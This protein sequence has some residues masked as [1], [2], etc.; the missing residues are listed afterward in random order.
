MNTDP[1]EIDWNS[2]EHLLAIVAGVAPAT[3][4]ERDKAI[5]AAKGRITF[6]EIGRYAKGYEAGHQWGYKMGYFDRGLEEMN[7]DADRIARMTNGQSI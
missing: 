7:K 1:Y 4:E 5:E 2:E 3:P 6:E